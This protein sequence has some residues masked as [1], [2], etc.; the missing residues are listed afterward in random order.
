M[1]LLAGLS[2][3][4]SIATAAAQ[5]AAPAVTGVPDNSLGL[6]FPANGDPDGR[7]KALAEKGVTYGVNYVGEYQAN[8]AGGIARGSTYIGRLEGILDVDLEKR[9]GLAGLTFH[10]N[11]Y[12]FHGKAL[13]PETVGSLMPVSFV[14]AKPTTRL[15]E[16][17]LEQ[18]VFATTT[19]RAGQLA[20]DSEFFVSSYATQFI[21]GSFGWPALTASNLPSGGPASPLATPGARLKV[22]PNGSLAFLAAIYN[23]DPAGPG[24]NDPQER[25]RYGLNFRLQ[26]QPL[27]M[28]EG[29]L[30]VNQ[31]KGASGLA[32]SYK[33]GAFT[34]FGTFDDQ[35]FSTDGR[36]LG[37]PASNGVPVS[38]RRDHGLY[39]VIDQQLWRPASGEADKGVGLFARAMTSP[40]D[41]NL[42]D[43]YLDGG[44][45][46]AGLWAARPD[47]VLSFG[48]AYARISGAA[49]AR[50]A[51]ALALAGAGLVR[52]AERLFEVNYQA[53][54]VPGLQV[55]LDLQRITSPSGGAPNP[56]DPSGATA[57]PAAT[58]LTL[59]TMIKY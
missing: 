54:I 47:D 5:G 6:N 41:R 29:Q 31:D 59:H 45:V 13:T 30:K 34:H 40:S 53:Q 11:I 23:G 16:A 52:N 32:G 1:L 51:D 46:F 37:D 22:E 50:D 42:I 7:R 19:V 2:V 21:N 15:F 57:I 14:E 58:V 43:L 8:V 56:A 25:N 12:N 35:R 20:A 36:S 10:T 55:D 28:T 4:V 9:L 24:T 44:I 49:R 38:R 33:L 27:V 3:A 39:A 26:D 18:K 17:W 48:A